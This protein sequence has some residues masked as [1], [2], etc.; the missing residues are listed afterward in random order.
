MH[1]RGNHWVKSGRREVLSVRQKDVMKE[2]KEKDVFERKSCASLSQDPSRKQVD[3]QRMQTI[4]RGH[5]DQ[6]VVQKLIG[7]LYDEE[8]TQ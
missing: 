7:S 5:M 8:I 6:F 3:E 4:R 2:R 1:G